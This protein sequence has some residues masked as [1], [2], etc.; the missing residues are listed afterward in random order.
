MGIGL[1]E[2][3]LR[4]GVT[5]EHAIDVRPSIVADRFYAVCQCGWATHDGK[6]ELVDIWVRKH[7]EQMTKAA[8]RRAEDEARRAAKAERK[9]EKA[10]AHAD[11][12]TAAKRDRSRC[13]RPRRLAFRT[14]RKAEAY[15]STKWQVGRRR[16]LPHHAYKC[17]C[18]YWHITVRPEVSP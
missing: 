5:T 9:A 8:I 13:P 4:D 11:A 10:R 1:P 12:L 15:I 7:H 3:E 17:E 6:P 16:K 18:N 14:Q 2:A